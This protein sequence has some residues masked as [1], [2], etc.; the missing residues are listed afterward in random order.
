MAKHAKVCPVCKKDF[1][2]GYGWQKYCGAACRFRDQ[3]P[4]EK[5]RSVI[6]TANVG[7]AHELLVCADLLKLGFAVYRSVSPSAAADLI[8]FKR[9]RMF[10]VEVTTG[11]ITATGKLTYAKPDVDPRYDVLAVV[12]WN[13]K[14]TYKPAWSDDMLKRG[15]DPG[16]LSLEA[17]TASETA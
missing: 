5:L 12:E 7:A 13:N 1:S 9:G 8:V 15:K 3:R 10:R 17:P 16:I 14:V 2:V 4:A 6:C 11:H